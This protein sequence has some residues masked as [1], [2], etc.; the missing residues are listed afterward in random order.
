MAYRGD[1]RIVRETVRVKSLLA[2]D[3]VALLA[4]QD[5]M[6]EGLYELIG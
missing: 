6:T 3:S 4:Q 2:A 5:Q 1:W